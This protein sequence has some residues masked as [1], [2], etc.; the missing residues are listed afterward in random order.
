[1]VDT[2]S[3]HVRYLGDSN[4][5]SG[6]VL[7][8]FPDPPG[9]F[10]FPGTLGR[11]RGPM[12]A[13]DVRVFVQ[14]RMASARFPGKALAPL[15]GKP[16]IEHVLERV[17]KAVNLD[18]IVLCTTGDPSDAPLVWFAERFFAWRMPRYL[19][20]YRG[21]AENVV[22]RFQEAL[23]VYPCE[24]FFRVC[25]DSPLL[26]PGLFERF[27]AVGDEPDL[28]T[29]VFPRTFP[30][31]QSL[32]LVRSDTF[33]ALDAASLTPEQREHPTKVYYENPSQ[34][35]IVNVMSGLPPLNANVAVDTIEDLRRIEAML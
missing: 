18:Q 25:G 15:A 4:G 17:A 14:A 35:S 34:Y 8:I 9:V 23:R 10:P 29:N 7:S 3:T 16:V 26:D 5:V 22:S 6:A 31:G 12:V 20:V 11:G 30:R 13:G 24:R 27:L 2:F 1:M 19:K 32:E 21:P 33:A 28:V